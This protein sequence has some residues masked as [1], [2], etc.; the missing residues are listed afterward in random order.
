MFLNW[1]VATTV[2]WD[3]KQEIHFGQTKL[4]GIILDLMNVTKKSFLVIKCN[5]VLACN[6]N[7]TTQE[8][9]SAVDLKITSFI[10]DIQK[11]IHNSF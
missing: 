10:H 8:T 6:C 1:M 5:L 4:A 3:I 7:W 2:S 11:N 9:F